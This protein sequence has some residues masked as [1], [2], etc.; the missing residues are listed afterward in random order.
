T[1][2]F[3]TIPIG[4]FLGGFLIDRVFEPWMAV[5]ATDS[6][7][8]AVFGTG[9]GAG[10]ALLFFVIAIVGVLTCLLFRKDPHIWEL[11]E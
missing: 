7:L 9:K 1:L 8:G 11:E 6:L 2:Q 4:Y 5:Q 10:A 3:F